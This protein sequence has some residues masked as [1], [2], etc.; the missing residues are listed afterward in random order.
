V[1]SV[2]DY[3]RKVKPSNWLDGDDLAKQETMTGL[4]LPL[5][6]RIGDLVPNL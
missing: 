3:G 6:E 2:K 4:D 5:S 1:S